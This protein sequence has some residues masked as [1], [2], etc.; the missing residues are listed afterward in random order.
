MSLH[1]KQ[2]DLFG[3]MINNKNFYIFNNTSEEDKIEIASKLEKFETGS[4]FF[5][6]YTNKDIYYMFELIE[7]SNLIFSDINHELNFKSKIDIYI[8]CL[9][10][11]YLISNFISKNRIIL[12]K[13]ISDIKK[14]LDNFYSENQTDTNIQ[15]KINNYI[16]GL[17]GTTNKKSKKRNPLVLFNVNTF[18]KSDKVKTDSPNICILNNKSN[19]VS[20][21]IKIIDHSINNS[22][23]NQE[24]THDIT[25]NTNNYYNNYNY[26]FNN[27][28]E[29]II[30]D[31]TTPQFPSKIIED[32]INNTNNNE[33]N[34]NMLK[35]ESINSIYIENG[36]ESNKNFLKKESIH[37]YYTLGAKSRDKN[38]G[39]SK[40]SGQEKEKIVSKFSKPE[41][42]V[43]KEISKFKEFSKE[44]KNSNNFDNSIEKTIKNKRTVTLKSNIKK[45]N[46]YQISDDKF[47]NRNDEEEIKKSKKRTFSSTDLKSSK[48][49]IM[50]KNLLVLINDIFKKK[51]IDSEQ[52]L[53]IK[54]LIISK[55]KKLDYTYI[56]YYDFNKEKFINELINLIR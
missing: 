25:N 19:N 49:K 1:Y 52:K 26:N 8:S 40:F 24:K 9:S 10:N 36:E 37:S 56:M 5:K 48:E 21:E 16:S 41:K 34:K 17:L 53:K 2:F 44:E 47:N 31:L 55:S 15:K 23:L 43:S 28:E 27:D 51:I 18:T 33:P 3:K 45:N 38:K 42:K 50:L 13:A 7:K 11:I 46:H 35:Q 54:Q 29:H 6:Y 12:N 39:S 30:F 14:K 4:D 32:D 20:T 22:Y